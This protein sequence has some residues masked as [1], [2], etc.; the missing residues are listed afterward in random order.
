MIRYLQRSKTKLRKKMIKLTQEQVATLPE[1]LKS[2]TRV[3]VAREWKVRPQ[4][5]VSFGIAIFTSA[6]KT[7][8]KDSKLRL[9]SP[10]KALKY[11]TLFSKFVVPIS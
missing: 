9:N 7:P 3:E 2:K 4:N 1:L 6:F 11:F 8:L 5:I 10:S